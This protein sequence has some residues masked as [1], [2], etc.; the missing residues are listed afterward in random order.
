[1][2][3]YIEY[4]PQTTGDAERDI[5]NLHAYLYRLCETLNVTFANLEKDRKEG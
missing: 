4:P 3:E 1:M 2:P 5:K